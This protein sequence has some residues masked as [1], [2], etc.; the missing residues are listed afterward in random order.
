ME[1][2]EFLLKLFHA[3]GS[4]DKE[5]KGCTR[6][7]RFMKDCSSYEVNIFTHTTVLI[8]NYLKKIDIS[9]GI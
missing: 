6:F 3:D 7:K 8:S 5:V 1:K 4:K 2:I 9:Q